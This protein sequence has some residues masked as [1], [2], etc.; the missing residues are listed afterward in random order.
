MT[1]AEICI[2]RILKHEGGYVNNRNDKGGPTNRGITIATFRRYVKPKG[3]IT[4]L[5]ALTEAQAV[6][7]YKRQYWDRVLADMLPHGVD[8]AVADYAVNSGPSRAAKELQRVV[9]A[10]PDGKIGPATLKAV[11]AMATDTIIRNLC[12][13]RLRFMKAIR[14]GRDWKSFGRGWQR[15][16]DD[17]QAHALNDI[18]KAPAPAAKPLSGIIAAILALFRKG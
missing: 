13:R 18:A 3:T 5:K 6:V 8:Y 9:G 7:V 11:N 12:S 10:V 17:V 15:R 4:D 14:G 16:V 2:P 1:R